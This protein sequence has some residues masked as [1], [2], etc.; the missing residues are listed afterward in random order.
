MQNELLISLFNKKL[1]HHYSVVE[2]PTIKVMEFR[3]FLSLISSLALGIFTGVVLPTFDHTSDYW[4]IHDTY[5]FQGNGL[6]MAG[7]RACYGKL[8]NDIYEKHYSPQSNC[9][10]CVSSAEGN[11]QSGIYCSASPSS[12]DTINKLQ[13]STKCETQNWHLGAKETERGK[14]VED[15]TCCIQSR[16][17]LNESTLFDPRDSKDSKISW[18]FCRNKINCNYCDFFGNQEICLGIGSST[19]A[20]CVE[21][22][23]SFVE[24][25]VFISDSLSTLSSSYYL[26]NS[27]NGKKVF[28]E[29]KCKFEGGCCL[30]V[31]HINHAQDLWRCNEDVC[32]QHI[33]WL[34]TE[35]NI[36][37]DFSSWKENKDFIHGRTVGG[38]LCKAMRYYALSLIVPIALNFIFTFFAWL[39]DYRNGE[40]HFATI[41]IVGLQFYPQWRALRYMYSSNDRKRQ[42]IDQRCVS[43]QTLELWES[44]LQV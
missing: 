18:V 36:I 4:L 15:D 22:Y 41:L 29:G 28:K 19:S 10:V 40:T 23:N 24:S 32:K 26:T 33:N 11:G 31:K 30:T 44:V 8:E 25:R 43:L 20:K 3:V 39:V 9:N 13:K 12:L 37:K 38:K 1:N 6:E 21:S 16:K 2:R 17:Y 7:C 35:S 14:C 34:I 5:N 42:G 27:I